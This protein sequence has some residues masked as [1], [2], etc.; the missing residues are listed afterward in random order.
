MSAKNGSPNFF[1]K[2]QAKPFLQG[3]FM[4][5]H[6]FKGISHYQGY[7]IL[8]RVCHTFKGMSHY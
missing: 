1:E 2:L 6:T 8:L 7:V 4:V 3:L 5:C